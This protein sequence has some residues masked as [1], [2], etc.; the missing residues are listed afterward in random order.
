MKV[1]HYPQQGLQF[2]DWAITKSC[3]LCYSLGIAYLVSQPEAA[4]PYLEL[5]LQ[6]A[7]FQ[8]TSIFI[9]I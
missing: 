6:A 3:I 4:I 9:Q 1:I 8:V 2:T 5:G 7:Q